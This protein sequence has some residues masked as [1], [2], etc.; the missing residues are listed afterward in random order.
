MTI[1][2]VVREICKQYGHRDAMVYD[3]NGVWKRYTWKRYYDT[4][5]QIAAV[6]VKFGLHVGEGVSILGFNSP[7]WFLCNLAAIMAGGISVGIYTTNSAEICEYIIKDSNS[8]IVVVENELQLK[9][10][11]S[12]NG[13]DRIKAIIQYTGSLNDSVKCYH[14]VYD[15]NTIM[16]YATEMCCI[17]SSER[18]CVEQVN[19]VMASLKPNQCSTIIYTSGT[20]SNIP[21]G[22]MLSHDNVIWTAKTVLKQF[23]IKQSSPQRVVSYL[24]LSH[25]AGQMIDIYGMMVNGGATWFAEPTA[26]KGTLVKTLLQAKPT[27]FLGVPRVWEKIQD[28]I[29]AS[30]KGKFKRFIMDKAMKVGYTYHQRLECNYHK[31]P[32]HWDFFDKLVFRKIKE[33]LGLSCC[34]LF[35]SGAAPI[36]TETLQF[37]ASIGIHI[38]NVYGMSECSGPMSTS[39]P[40][41][42]KTGS[43]GRRLMST[44]LMI[45]PETGEICTSGR[46]VMMGYLNNPE[47]TAETIDANGWL[48]SGDIGKLDNDGYL[49]VTGRIKD[50][51]I[52]AGGENIAPVPI[53]DRLKNE[54]LIISN[55]MVIGDKRKF[56]SVLVTLKC[57]VD[58]NGNPTDALDP[59]VIAY[60]QSVGSSTKTVSAARKDF[61]VLN[62]IEQGLVR[63]NTKSTSNAH[64]VYKFTIL[65]IDFSINGGELGPTLK[66]KRM[67]VEQKYQDLIEKMYAG[68]QP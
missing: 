47:K 36:Q 55:C 28:Q 52:T 13:T 33:K 67:V 31:K 15:W 10:I 35:L 18:T 1:I 48:H 27:I 11:L 29:N 50:L 14:N 45:N 49:Y 23:N 51:L 9:K 34:K 65:P 62:C 53:E 58:E 57:I 32:D 8:Q 3:D 22:V 40:Y 25:V 5:L 63:S 38:D 56:L 19:D 17:E 16:M 37:F 12:I 39:S 61:K 26:L 64:N 21:K 68:E 44:E 7:E 6:F 43:C 2:D 66:L 54:V 24:P 59:S 60:L 46:H 42:F 4:A 30:I 41:M 20:T